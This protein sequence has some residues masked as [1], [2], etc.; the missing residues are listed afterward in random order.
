MF[1]LIY[2]LIF[3]FSINLQ[4]QFVKEVEDALIQ[5]RNTIP[6][7]PQEI[8]FE[9]HL[10]RFSDEWERYANGTYQLKLYVDPKGPA[11]NVDYS[12]LEFTFLN[13]SQLNLDLTIDK[14]TV[15]SINNKYYI[16]YKIM[17]NRLVINI[18]GPE[19]YD[20]ALIVPETDENLNIE[21]QETVRIGRFKVRHTNPRLRIP[22]VIRW[23][24]PIPYFQSTAFKNSEGLEVFGIFDYFNQD[25]KIEIVN[26]E[27][28][29][30]Y[31]FRNDPSE[32]PP[33]RMGYFSARYVGGEKIQ[34][35]W[36]VNSEIFLQGFVIKRKILD[37]FATEEELADLSKYDDA[38]I[39]FTFDPS[40]PERFRE[41]MVGERKYIPTPKEYGPIFD[42]L[43]PDELVANR[44]KWYCY[45]LYRVDFISNGVF[46]S[47]FPMEQAFVQIPNSVIAYAQASP[48]PFSRSTRIDYELDDDVVLHAAVYDLQG[49]VVKELV[50][51]GSRVLKGTYTVDLTMPESATQGLYNLIFTASPLND[52][53]VRNSTAIV[54]LQ[55]IK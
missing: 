30:A 41:E 53:Q 39:V 54:K 47:E 1:K 33:F 43:T 19:K 50:P 36:R 24:E 20:D 29:I 6:H 14:P 51:P 31:R 48:N 40:N 10:L 11:I 23:I 25:D 7:S 8:D 26:P 32:P 22:P 44:G 28:N 38:P 52:E 4:S 5:I 27:L 15:Q 9:L 42:V 17:D 35:G 46:D 21:E 55:M 34:L 37:F 18:L 3:L 13:D 45:M 12:Q 16:E 2:I 49:K